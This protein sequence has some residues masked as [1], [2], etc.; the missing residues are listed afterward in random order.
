MKKLFFSLFAALLL[1]T[2]NMAA[3]ACAYMNITSSG[4]S[5]SA[6]DSQNVYEFS[7]SCLGTVNFKFEDL[8]GNNPTSVI[9]HRIEK[10][11]GGSWRLVSGRTSNGARSVSRSFFPSS[12]GKYRYR[13]ENV[14]TSQVRNWRM[15]GRMP[16]F[17][18]P[19]T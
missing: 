7:I 4:A 17:T 2:S 8:S 18:I 1:S 13:I 5:L 3:A 10:Q 11:E 16:L 6:G 14:G 15:E 9:N 19:G 12:T